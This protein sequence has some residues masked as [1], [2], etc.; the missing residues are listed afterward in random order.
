L[1]GASA[2]S[3]GMITGNQLRRPRENTPVHSDLPNT[4]GKG[5]MGGGDS[6]FPSDVSIVVF[7]SHSSEGAPSLPCL[8]RN[9][10]RA[11]QTASL[12]PG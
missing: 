9:R 4:V 3:W 11:C 7:A 6:R 1:I 8:G 10:G 12:G 5:E 2:A